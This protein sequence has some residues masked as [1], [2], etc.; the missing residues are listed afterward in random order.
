M[1]SFRG[2]EAPDATQRQAGDGMRTKWGLLLSW[3]GQGGN[4][5]NA[6]SCLLC[7]LCHQ[8]EHAL[9]VWGQ[10]LPWRGRWR[11]ELAGRP[12][13]NL[14]VQKRK[15]ARDTWR[16]ALDARALWLLSARQTS[17]EEGRVR[18]SPSRRGECRCSCV[19]CLTP[20]A[21][22]WPSPSTPTWRQPRGCWEV[23]EKSRAWAQGDSW[24]SCPVLPRC[25]SHE[26]NVVSPQPPWTLGPAK[27]SLV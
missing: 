9:W 14:A 19:A 4:I 3:G 7:A 1:V 24:G 21:G 13:Q 22:P 5:W 2:L 26:R 12:R 11:P 8:V 23:S 25:H 16:I 6:F 10:A 17:S 15:V 20:T 18:P 27:C